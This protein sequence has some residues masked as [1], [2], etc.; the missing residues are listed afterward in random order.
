[1]NSRYEIEGYEAPRSIE[2]LSQRELML[3]VGAALWLLLALQAILA[4]SLVDE[5]MSSSSWAARLVIAGYA[6]VVAI[7]MLT[8]ARRIDDDRT[9]L[10]VNVSVAT[11]TAIEL[12][13]STYGQGGVA[14]MY[15][16][17]TATAI[18]AGQFLSLR[19]IAIQ[20]TLVTAFAAIGVVVHSDD[21]LIP[22]MI[23]RIVAL[24]PIYWAVAF[25]VYALRM[26]RAGAISE[27]ENYAFSD[28]LTGLVNLRAL[29]QRG[30]AL[31]AVRNERINRPTGLLVIDLDGFRA[32][33]IL[34]GHLGGDRLLRDIADAM[35]GL[36]ESHHSLARTGSDE[37]MVLVENADRERLD[38]IAELYRRAILAASIADDDSKPPIDASIGRA[39]S[40]GDGRTFDELLMIADRDMYRVKLEHEKRPTA[41]GTIV[42]H[43]DEMPQLKAQGRDR[44]ST[45]VPGSKY[46][47]RNRPMQVRYVTVSWVLTA[48]V[49]LISLT[50][51]DAVVD[52]WGA[53]L[54]LTLFAYV[55]T[56]IR[57]FSPPST[58]AWQQVID[59]LVALG[60]LGLMTY[61]TGGAGSPAWPAT[62][63]VL[64]YVGW[65]MSLRWIVPM[66]LVTAATLALPFIY[67]DSGE[68]PIV[69]FVA[70]IGGVGVGFALAAIMFYNHFFLER[71]QSLGRR[72]EAIDPRTGVHNRREFERRLT[73]EIDAL[74]YGDIDAL[75]IVMLDLGDFKGVTAA[76]GRGGADG[77]L[78]DVGEVLTGASR[79]EDCV[80][81]LGGDEFAV[82][83]PGVNADTARA[84]AQRFVRAVTDRVT[85]PD[86]P[87]NTNLVPSAGFA[88]YGMHGRTNEELITAA[89]VALTAAKT[90]GRS[91]E[92]VSSFVV[93]L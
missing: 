18:F 88:L 1:M 8:W 38:E 80:A 78:T 48:T 67:E 36:A 65:F 42:A 12:F 63:L 50:M 59:V 40:P 6:L 72:L 16:A 13:L 61:W 51:P 62:L 23:A 81:R 31:L 90:T 9:Y 70:L 52:N 21:P 69:E 34:R 3:D 49:I 47:W 28:P 79:A 68:L 84:L 77:L 17:Y 71:A 54:T 20:L 85:S 35:R 4:G 76:I 53:V 66:T 89:D 73:T 60:A 10:L 27:V 92:R 11:V 7:S 15:V 14:I 86:Y 41:A 58:K 19:E 22:H 46:G 44:A 37:F 25:S 56:A 24:V 83:L 26:D 74:S 32:A 87:A 29:R 55:L 5:P 33:N 75:A 39:I 57:Y 2:P 30:D 91:E 45:V 64:V 43:E 93:A 82:I